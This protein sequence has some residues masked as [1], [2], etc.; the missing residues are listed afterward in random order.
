MIKAKITVFDD[1]TGE[2][3]EKDR[4]IAPYKDETLIGPGCCDYQVEDCEFRFDF[5]RIR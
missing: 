5:K 1:E 2:V 3:F 4:V